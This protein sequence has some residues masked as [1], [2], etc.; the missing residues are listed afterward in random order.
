LREY[1][2]GLPLPDDCDGDGI[3]D[4]DE[5]ANGFATDLNGNGVPDNCE[6]A[7]GL[8]VDR[9]HNGVPDEYEAAP[10]DDC[11]RNGISDLNEIFLGIATDTNSNGIPD[12]CEV[13][14][15]TVPVQPAQPAEFYRALEMII[16]VRGENEFEIE[17]RGPLEKADSVAG[18]WTEEP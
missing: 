10:V 12:E 7:E 3:S 17:Y 18:P 6:I 9:D 11:N 2:V 13:S 5:I 1:P 16:K 4:A 15:R 14:V 8:L